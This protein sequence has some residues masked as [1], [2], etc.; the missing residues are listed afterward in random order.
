M[1]RIFIIA[2]LLTFGVV[3]AFAQEKLDANKMIQNRVSYMKGALK[4]SA[5]ESKAF[6]PAYEQFL[7]NEIKLHETYRKNIE[8]ENA[9][10]V[11]RRAHR[12]ADH[13]PVRPEV[14]ASQ[15]PA[16]PGDHLLQEN[17]DHPDSQ[18][19]AGVL[20][21][22]RKIQTEL[23]NQQQEGSPRSHE[24]AAGHTSQSQEIKRQRG[25]IER[26]FLLLIKK[27]V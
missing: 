19:P 20:Q 8:K 3:A 15:K 5:A 1:K 9:K 13:L 18:E 23:G 6:W 26:P 2:A 7:R 16:D 21:K 24:R 25:R 12:R 11:V 10:Q 17:Q 22:R 27:S 4:L 14:R